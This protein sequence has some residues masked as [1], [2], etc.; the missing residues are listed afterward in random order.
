MNTVQKILDELKQELE[1]MSSEHARITVS[2]K[3]LEMLINAY[4]KL[5]NESKQG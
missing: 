4:E 5:K 3:N 1:E 2:R